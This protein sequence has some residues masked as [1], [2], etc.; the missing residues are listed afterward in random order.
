[1]NQKTREDCILYATWII[2]ELAKRKPSLYE[3]DKWHRW[4]EDE[5]E[6]VK[7]LRG[8]LESQNALK[9]MNDDC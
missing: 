9:V 5:L 1:M 8:G 2:N 7:L 4:I 3:I 6:L